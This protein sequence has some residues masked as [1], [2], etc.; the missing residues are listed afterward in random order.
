MHS[1]L[2]E[3]LEGYLSGSLFP[4]EQ[5]ALESHL[6]G[7]PA[8]RRELQVLE[9]SAQDLRLL[10]P[11]SDFEAHVAPGF[12]LKVMRR[13]EEEREAPFWSLLLDPSFGRR[14]V[15][16]CLMVL[17]LLGGYLAAVDD[18][19]F[20]HMPEAILAGRPVDG[21]PQ[22]NRPL[23]RGSDLDQNRG[24]VLATLAADIE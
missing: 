24:A 11:P 15:F 23:L 18:V 13:I 8:C 1:P 10:R 2:Q 17:A 5:R 19:E 14:L 12:F 21:G 6:A 3:N 4:A 16:A 7:C 22:L 20:R 9:G